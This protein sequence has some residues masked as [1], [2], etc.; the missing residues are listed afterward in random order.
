[1]FCSC[2]ACGCARYI[3]NHSF[4]THSAWVCVAHGFHKISLEGQENQTIYRLDYKSMHRRKVPLC[5]NVMLYGSHIPPGSLPT[6]M[7]HPICKQNCWWVVNGTP[8]VIFWKN[9]SLLPSSLSPSFPPF[10]DPS[11]LPANHLLSWRFSLEFQTKEITKLNGA[12]KRHHLI[13]AGQRSYTRDS[14]RVS[15]ANS[16][17]CPELDCSNRLKGHS[18]WILQNPLLTWLL[19]QLLIAHTESVSLRVYVCVYCMKGDYGDG[20]SIP[21]R[22]IPILTL[23]RDLEIYV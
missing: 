10:L 7:A 13:S 11:I 3:Y 23:G 19:L 9:V 22:M 21:R 8:S 12:S 2:C 4:L 20:R 5:F 14:Q 18:E 16:L 15:R 6:K 17:S 1:M